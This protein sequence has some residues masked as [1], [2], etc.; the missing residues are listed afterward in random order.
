MD[1][2]KDWVVHREPSMA[3][4]DHVIRYLGQYMHRVAIS[5]RN[6]TNITD[7]HVE[8]IAKDYRDKAKRKPTKL[9]GVEFLRRFCLHILP[10][11]FVKIRYFGIYNATTK[12]KLQLQFEKPSIDN[13][14]KKQIIKHE[15]VAQCLKRILN[16]DITKCPVCKKGTMHKINE[17]P[18]I[19]SPA[20]HLPSL[21]AT[22]L[23]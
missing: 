12:R 3:D 15:T 1:Y 9:T 18:R 11:H 4:A 17:I 2:K 10:S 5:N 6:I 16:I 22:L 7:T 8:F 14:H 21:L 23:V 19:R 20:G 13:I